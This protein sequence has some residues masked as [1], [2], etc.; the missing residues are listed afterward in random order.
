MQ[1]DEPCF[2]E[3]RSERELDA[4]RLAYEELGEGARA[5]PDPGQDLLRPRRRRL[6]RPARPARSRASG[7]T[8]TAAAKNVELI[9]EQGGLEDQCAVRRHRRRAQRLDQRARAQPRPAGRPARPAATSS[10]SPR[11]ARCCTRPS[12]STPSRRVAGLDD[13]LRSWMAFAS[14]RSA[15]SRPWP[16]PRRGPRGDRATSSTPTTARS[17]SRRESQ[18]TATRR[19][20]SGWRR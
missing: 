16:G 12:T 1:L 6:R 3:D 13:E 4:L 11:R 5:H 20:A 8:S 7:S 17:T 19:S 15:R 9:A 18:R 2:V 10:S 14:R